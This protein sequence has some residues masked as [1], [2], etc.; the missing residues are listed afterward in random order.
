VK[1]LSDKE[2]AV[3]NRCRVK[4]TD[5]ALFQISRASRFFQNIKS[6]KR[7]AGESVRNNVG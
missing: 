3:E 2:K 1:I 7:K 5:R 4:E 6:H